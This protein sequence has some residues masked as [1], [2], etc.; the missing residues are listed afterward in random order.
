LARL[1]NQNSD[2]DVVKAESWYILGKA[3]HA[4][5]QYDFAFQFYFEA[6]KYNPDHLLATFG[7]GQMYIFKG[8]IPEARKCFEK[9]YEKD[10]TNVE[11]LKVLG[12]ILSKEKSLPD[13]KKAQSFLKKVVEINPED[14]ET[15]IELAE[16]HEIFDLDEA[17]HA[18]QKAEN[19]WETQIKGVLPP[20]LL[21]NIGALY[22]RRDMFDK[23]RDYFERAI[24]S[25]EKQM[26]DVNQDREYY[27]NLFV[28]IKYNLARAFEELNWD[29]KAKEIYINISK[30]YPSYLDCY[31]RLGCISLKQEQYQEANDWLSEVLGIDKDNANAWSLMGLIHL[32]KNE[33]KPAKK[34]V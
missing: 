26:E 11:N 27:R 18:Y 5:E 25:S 24:E 22:L 3:N 16:V 30:E 20:E 6:C 12:S 17:L 13:Q 7:L 10:P 28:T 23:A 8:N 2:V 19:I 21:N 31:L 32:K 15:W 9:V 33:W 29:E 1:G 34:E 4:Q 14:V